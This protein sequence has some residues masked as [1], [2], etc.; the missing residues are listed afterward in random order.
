MHGRIHRAFMG[1][2]IVAISLGTSLVHA[3]AGSEKEAAKTLYGE[4]IAQMKEHQF[5]PACVK[6]EE[7]VR[8]VPSGVGAKLTLADCYLGAGKLASAYSAYL[9]ASEAALQAK[10]PD[11][12]MVAREEAETLKPRISLLSLALPS[13]LKAPAGWAVHLDG[14]ELSLDKLSS[15]ILV[16]SGV[17]TLRVEAPGYRAWSRSVDIPQ[18]GMHLQINVPELIPEAGAER[19]LIWNPAPPK[20]A[21]SMVGGLATIYA[22]AFTLAGSA[23]AGIL[24]ISQYSHCD[25]HNCSE[26]SRL[27]Y[28]ES[29]KTAASAS[30]VM[31]ISGGMILGVGLAWYAAAARDR[32][33]PAAGIRVG[34]GNASL[35]VH[36]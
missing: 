16:D 1:L 18:D 26:E 21:S 8:L 30:T 17:H 5:A 15:T 7:V 2:G 3:E 24:A 35:V 22:G 20:G 4:A 11:R 12:A 28:E 19:E 33:A 14:V 31:A 36:W 13:I 29:S 34:A 23:A 25:R 32:D 27:H 10:Q 6:L 9:Q